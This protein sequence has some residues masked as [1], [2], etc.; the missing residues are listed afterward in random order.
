MPPLI[1]RRLVGGD[2]PAGSLLP[3]AASQGT[4]DRSPSPRPGPAGGGTGASGAP[5]VPTGGVD[6]SSARGRLDLVERYFAACSTG[7]AEEIAACFTG[8]AAIFDTNLPPVRGDVACGRFWTRVRARWG[9]ASW[10]L[11]HGIAD[12]DAVACE[13][14]MRGIA[15][16]GRPVTF[17]GSDH[18]RFDG[19]R[20]AEVRQ[21][22]VFDRDGLVSGLLEYPYDVHGDDPVGDPP[23]PTAPG[24]S[25]GP[26]PAASSS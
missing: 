16:G 11:D 21:Y 26:S 2:I 10:H 20:I 9:G 23:P 14:T 22:W 17:R 15:E 8:D 12:G 19:D 24:S 4:T 13:W 5:G 25:P 3:V 1:A 6:A 18:Y 7:T